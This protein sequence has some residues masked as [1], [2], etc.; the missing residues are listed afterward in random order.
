MRRSHFIPVL[1]T[2]LIG[3]FVSVLHAQNWAYMN[4]LPSSAQL[5]QTA[6]G[7]GVYVAV[8]GSAHIVSSSDGVT[9]TLR[10]L[11]AENQTLNA[12]AFGNG[13]F[14]AVGTGY[15]GKLGSALIMTSTDGITWTADEA[16][17]T[18]TQA[19]FFDVIYAGGLWVIT[20]APSNRV[21]TSTDGVTWTG[22][23]AGVGTT[24]IAHGNGRFVALSSDNRY[25]T[26][27][28]G[29]TWTTGFMTGSA[30][31]FDHGFE[32]IIFANNQFT[33]VGRDATFAGAVFSS[34]DGLAWSKTATIPGNSLIRVAYLNGTYVTTG[35]TGG[36]TP[37]HTSPDG[38]V[39]T[40]RTSAMPPRA[41]GSPNNTMGEGIYGLD[42][43]NGI[44]FA[45]GGYGSVTTSTDGIAW[46]RR[47]RGSLHDI[48]GLIWDGTRFVGTGSGGTVVTSPDGVQWTASQSNQA[49]VWFGRLAYANNRYVTAGIGG[50]YHSTDLATWTRVT[51]D[52]MYGVVHDNGKFVAAYYG[53]LGLGLR[54][55]TDGVTWATVEV[56]GRDNGGT[57]GLAGG[58]GAFV[59]ATGGF[60]GAPRLY[61]S[62]DA[63]TWSNVTPS[64]LT[65]APQYLAYGNGRFVVVASNQI[66]VSTDGA[67]WTKAPAMADQL[68]YL[69]HTG[70]RFIARSH[71][72]GYLTSTDG[73]TWTRLANSYG[74][75]I[76]ATAAVERDGRIY[77]ASYGGTILRSEVPTPVDPGRI[78]NMSIRTHAGTGDNTLIVGLGLGG[79]GAAGSKALLVRGVGPTL[80]KYGVAN[81]LGDPILTAYQGNTQTAQNDDWTGDFDFN[82]VGAFPFEGSAPK[83][84]A[85]YNPALA[86]GTYSVQITGKAGASGIALAEIYDATPASAFTA[87]SPRLINV[88][89]RARVG[90]GDGVLIAG[91]VI[92]GSTPVKVLVRAAGPALIPHGVS[93]A[94]ANPKLELYNSSKAK[95]AENDDW[96]GAAEVKTAA[97]AVYAFSFP[98]DTSTDAALLVTL[99]PGLYTAQA[100]GVGDTTGVA[101][102]E[103]YE[104]P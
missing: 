11:G 65:N 94:L 70:S 31:A 81:A 77:L 20:N 49:S 52:Q 100:S 82:S 67:A 78:V 18:N 19:Q 38:L 14:V 74:P 41:S 29:L 63:A 64:G 59:V 72:G 13:R 96:A 101:L 54:T 61:R 3:I 36:N 30:Q 99:E 71:N 103:V 25:S 42:A 80:T 5:N 87:T 66:W 89:A 90:T 9:W 45:T 68:M 47:T 35:N 15:P 22:R 97:N 26:S 86:I 2:C 75:N 24:K 21:L 10:H 12:V 33:A 102:V 39:W 51:Q 62:T 44:L 32:D 46:T 92:G 55:S 17:A 16:M 40:A 85:L 50:L 8:G 76:E 60:G 27:T 84:A 23:A 28:D 57:T 93:G 73:N 56:P 37:L 34:A 91:F 88:S 69:Q 58:G 1:V 48:N 79:T 104:V 7:N 95:I 83:D 98:S 53:G 6:F 4:P 43:V